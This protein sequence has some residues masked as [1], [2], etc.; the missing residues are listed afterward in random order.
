MV[1]GDAGHRMPGTTAGVGIEAKSLTGA[2]LSVVCEIKRLSAAPVSSALPLNQRA[3]SDLVRESIQPKTPAKLCPVK[4]VTLINPPRSVV[5]GALELVTE[6]KGDSTSSRSPKLEPVVPASSHFLCTAAQSAPV[7][8]T[9]SGVDSV[10]Q[11][12]LSKRE[13]KRLRKQ[14]NSRRSQA[15]K[16]LRQTS[17]CPC[18]LNVHLG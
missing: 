4:S 12:P 6:T 13:K 11:P 1:A 2:R 8:L 15:P 16:D 14:R 18:S 17:D 3:H 7:E 10:A 9:S 5:T